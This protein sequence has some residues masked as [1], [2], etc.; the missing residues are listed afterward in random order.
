MDKWYDKERLHAAADEGNLEEVKRLIEHGYDVNAFDEGMS[1]TPLHYAIANQDYKMAEYLLEVGADI[2]ANEE[3]KIG[4]TPL[5]HV[6]ANCSYT[7]AEFLVNHGANPIIPGWMQLTA[8]DRAKERKKDE[9][10]RVYELLLKIAVSR[11]HYKN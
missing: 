4:D 11:F 6:A 1:F 5:G 10:K 9:G 7:M 3:E 8:L 2:N